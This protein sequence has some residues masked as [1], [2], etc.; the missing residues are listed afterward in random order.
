MHS[1]PF[2]KE[3]NFFSTTEDFVL[4]HTN[5]PKPLSNAH[6]NVFIVIT[7][8]DFGLS[9]HQHV[10]KKRG[11]YGESVPLSMLL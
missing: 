4:S 5:V 7:C 11:C 2:C 8:L 10:Y 6:I 9:P 1:S 3:F